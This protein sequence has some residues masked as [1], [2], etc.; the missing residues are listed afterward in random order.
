MGFFLNFLGGAAQGAQNRLNIIDQQKFREKEKK[1]DRA[2]Q[3]QLQ[4]EEWQRRIQLE[5]ERE[6]VKTAAAQ[7]KQTQELAPYAKL[8]QNM[9]LTAEA[10]KQF[11]I[12]AKAANLD[13]KDSAQSELYLR[14]WEATQGTDIYNAPEQSFEVDL[15][16]V[17]DASVSLGTGSAPQIG[18]AAPSAV[19]ISTGSFDD[20]KQ[21]QLANKMALFDATVGVNDKLSAGQKSSVD[22]FKNQYIEALNSGDNAKANTILGSVR[23]WKSASNDGSQAYQF[24]AGEFKPTE[25]V[26]GSAVARGLGGT[27]T[28]DTFKGIVSSIDNAM[29]QTGTRVFNPY[30]TRYQLEGR[31]ALDPITA[32]RASNFRLTGQRVLTDYTALVGGE[33]KNPA[34]LVFSV[35]KFNEALGTTRVDEG[36]RR[37]FNEMALSLEGT[38]PEAANQ[39]RMLMSAKQEDPRVRDQ[40][41]VTLGRDLGSISNLEIRQKKSA[42]YAQ[43]SDNSQRVAAAHLQYNAYKTR[44]KMTDEEIVQRVSKD[45]QM[46][47][48]PHLARRQ[49]AAQ[50]PPQQTGQGAQ[51]APTPTPS[52]PTQQGTP[53]VGTPPVAKEA[54]QAAPS[55]IVLPAAARY[56]LT[57]EQQQQV[58]DKMLSNFVTVKD[59]HSTAEK[60]KQLPLGNNITESRFKDVLSNVARRSTVLTND[61]VDTATEIVD[62]ISEAEG[63]D[64]WTESKAEVIRGETDPM[65]A[66]WTNISNFFGEAYAETTSQGN[67]ERADYLKESLRSDWSQLPAFVQNDILPTMPEGLADD[68]GLTVSSEGN[69]AALSGGLGV[70]VKSLQDLY[71]SLTPESKEAVDATLDPLTRDL[72]TIEEPTEAP[73]VPTKEAPKEV[74]SEA[75]DAPTTE[76]K[77]TQS[78]LGEGKP[79][80]DPERRISTEPLTDA[81]GT[82]LTISKQVEKIKQMPE[83]KRRATLKEAY[84]GGN[85]DQAVLDDIY[86]YTGTGFNLNKAVKDFEANDIRQNLIDSEGDS[87]AGGSEV[88]HGFDIA[89]PETR[90][91]FAE[92]AKEVGMSD[93]RIKMMYEGRAVMTDAEKEGMLDLYL[94]EAEEQAQEILGENTDPLARKLVTD[95]VYNMGYSR[96]KNNFPSFVKAMQ[97]G[98]Y[99]EAQMQLAYGDTTNFKTNG[100]V[101]D[102]RNRAVRNIALLGRMAKRQQKQD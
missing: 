10:Q 88:G 45:F 39:I 13:L 25:D 49:E 50:K 84:E 94:N 23:N 70:A 37:A 89:T 78:S 97:K 87:A 27:L 28:E 85:Q 64:K 67:R 61:F 5:A 86:Q 101:R 100:Y 102:T 18:V 44:G 82:E 79:F 91:Q 41:G 19:N 74:V 60:V 80:N 71:G 62:L 36:T 46:D 3:R 66:L 96:V 32:T 2:F 48:A 65:E 31:Q 56:A 59:L 57:P 15:G 7:V 38:H 4:D 33:M 83:K 34:S 72:L 29:A 24:K 93:T 58:S 16:G 69:V 90:K 92:F 20:P 68:L 1:E 43:M 40:V 8:A 26:I 55:G 22:Y 12:D 53:T 99:K 52:A 17:T 51:P 35:Q 47:Y 21:R 30:Y 9:N 73:A 11:A 95:L 76:E 6:R 63:A 75:P 54:A 98:D 42:D 81:E 77:T 14:Q